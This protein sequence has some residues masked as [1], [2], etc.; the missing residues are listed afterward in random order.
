VRLGELEKNI[1]LQT[2]ISSIARSEDSCKVLIRILNIELINTAENF[3]LKW[4]IRFWDISGNRGSLEE[5]IIS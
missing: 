3:N 1:L 5:H 4:E 2:C